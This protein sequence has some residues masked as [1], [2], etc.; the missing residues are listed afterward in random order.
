VSLVLLVILV[1]SGKS[2]NPKELDSVKISLALLPITKK[3]TKHIV[4]KLN[5]VT[6]RT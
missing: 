3:A 6:P 5:L 1:R 4:A 2:A